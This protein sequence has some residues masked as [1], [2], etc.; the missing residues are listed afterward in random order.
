M[1]SSLRRPLGSSLRVVRRVRRRPPC[2]PRAC[3]QRAQPV[4][5][6]DV[7]LRRLIEQLQRDVVSLK[8]RVGDVE[9]AVFYDDDD[10]PDDEIDRSN[11]TQTTAVDQA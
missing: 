6:A 10:E 3:R 4:N 2:L 8:G 7:P 11:D 1:V 5:T 9:A